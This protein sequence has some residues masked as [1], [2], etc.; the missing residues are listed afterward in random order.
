M[1][2]SDAWSPT[3]IRMNT[4]FRKE[5]KSDFETNFY[6]LMNNSLFGK[7]MEN[8][9]YR[10]DVKIVRSRETDKIRRLVAS[11]SYVRHEIFGN[12]LA[13]I[14]MHKSRLFLNKPIYTGMT[15]LENSK[16]LMYDFFYN[17]LKA[18]YGPKCEL[19]YTD[20]DSLLL[21]IETDH[22]YRDMA[23]E[24]SL[25]DT[26]NYPKDHLLYSGLNKKVL[27][28][29]KDECAGRMI[30][31]A[32]AIRP[33]MY[34]ILEENQKN[35]KKAKGLK[36]NVVER[37]IRH[38]Q[39]KEALFKKKQFWHGRNILG[40]EGHEIYGTRVNKVS[41]SSFDAKRLMADDGVYTLAYG[42]KDIASTSGSIMH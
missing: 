10:V 39:Y 28:K 41:L 15:I 25:Y 30:N 34:L 16:S 33:K 1:I 19:I 36:K 32:V 18:R 4:E 7:T 2:R 14:H 26:S 11:P 9:R 31:E 38:E 27:G 3:Y 8:L 37:E 40:S 5:A 23:E 21:E 42:H 13:G 20:T 17:C 6:K 29:M 12:D 22:V 35:I 24:L